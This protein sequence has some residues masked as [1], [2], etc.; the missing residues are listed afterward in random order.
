[1]DFDWATTSSRAIS[2]SGGSK[3]AAPGAD[4][5]IDLLIVGATKPVFFHVESAD[6]NSKYTKLH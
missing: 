6:F 1:V 2:A 5:T 4:T 3:G